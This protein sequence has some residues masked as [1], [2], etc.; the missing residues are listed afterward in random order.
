M[1]SVNVDHIVISDKF[2]HSDDGLKYFVCYKEG[3]IVKPLCITF[4]QMRGY[5]QYFESGGKNLF[6]MIEDDRVLD[7]CNEIWGQIRKH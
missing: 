7:K 6:F 5:I 2:K 1:E 4:P 3:E